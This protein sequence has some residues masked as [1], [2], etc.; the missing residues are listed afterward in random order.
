MTFFVSAFDSTPLN[1]PNALGTPEAN[2]IR[3]INEECIVA[4]HFATSSLGGGSPSLMLR[5]TSPVRRGTEG[6]RAGDG[7]EKSESSAQYRTSL[8]RG[9]SLRRPHM[10]GFTEKRRCGRPLVSIALRMESPGHLDHAPISSQM[11][12]A[13]FIRPKQ[14]HPLQLRERIAVRVAPTVGDIAL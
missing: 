11:D 3:F 4:R 6:N 10:L 14:A 2:W 7:V 9:V 5:E 12:S 1:P 8:C 13:Q